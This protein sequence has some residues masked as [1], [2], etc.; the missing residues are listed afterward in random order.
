LLDLVLLASVNNKRGDKGRT[1]FTGVMRSV[2][3]VR[4]QVGPGTLELAKYHSKRAATCG[5]YHGLLFYRSMHLGTTGSV[6]ARRQHEK[7]DPRD[8]PSRDEAER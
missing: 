1:C 7:N 3:R 4:E 5:F 6:T 2:L 8:T